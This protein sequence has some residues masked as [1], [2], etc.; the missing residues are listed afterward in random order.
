MNRLLAAI[1]IVFTLASGPTAAAAS[2]ALSFPDA[3]AEFRTGGDTGYIDD[4]VDTGL[5]T[6]TADWLEQHYF[7]VV[8]PTES[9]EFSLPVLTYGL[10]EDAIFELLLNGVAL[11]EF[12]VRAAAG[13]TRS[14]ITGSGVVPPAAITGALPTPYNGQV[15]GIRLKYDLSPNAGG[16]AFAMGSLGAPGYVTFSSVSAVPEPA[17][18][19]LMIGGFALVGAAARRRRFASHSLAA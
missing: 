2:V 17:A 1:G 6:T 7:E 11:T 15:L 9:F 19:A 10:T 8:I 4:G 3:G 18:W 13:D 5:F 14:L 12:T 16:V